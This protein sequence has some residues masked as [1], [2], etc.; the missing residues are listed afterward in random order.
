MK[1]LKTKIFAAAVVLLMMAGANT[2]AQVRI[3]A[4]LAYATDFN[5]VGINLRGDYLI[6]EPWRVGADF[7]FYLT[8]AGYSVNELNFNGFYAFEGESVTPYLLGGINILMTSV[9]FGAWGGGKA[10]NSDIGLNL[11][12][13]LDLPFSDNLSGFGEAKIVLSGGTYLALNAGIKYA[14]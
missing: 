2:Y 13:G 1:N 9:D 4:G 7:T 10:S 14:F 3:G 12:G 11:G 8:G 6:T 5:E